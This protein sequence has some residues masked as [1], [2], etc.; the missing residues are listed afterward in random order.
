M[1]RAGAAS[2]ACLLLLLEAASADQVRLK[3]G[4]ILE[5][6]ILE[7]T[8]EGVTL[9][10]SAGTFQVSRDR[11]ETV[12]R[13]AYVPKPPPAPPSVPEPAPPAPVPAPVE[14]PS[15][16]VPD[17]RVPEATEDP[18]KAKVASLLPAFRSFELGPEA[19]KAATALL[20]LGRPAAPVL[21]GFLED[22][23]PFQRK[24]LA[25]VLGVLKDPG[26]AAALLD[27]VH[28]PKAEVRGAAA[29]ALGLLKSGMAVQPLI[30]LL[31]DGSADVRLEAVRA[32][33]VLQAP[34]AVPALI[35]LLSDKDRYVAGA[36]YDALTGLTGEALPADP[37]PWREW[38]R[39]HPIGAKELKD[40]TGRPRGSRK[41]PD[42]E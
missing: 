20:E 11:I 6:Q 13:K 41:P 17:R 25:D 2:L 34:K 28:D 31:N 9:K 7:E 16:K 26:S 1:R 19:E 39:E 8:P 38:L 32:L 4:G 35:P 3:S 10:S 36:A 15:G 14:A 24:W 22:A 23:D 12:V 37:E 40:L 21:E 18:L 30:N 33:A 5:G 42:S 27:L 29:R